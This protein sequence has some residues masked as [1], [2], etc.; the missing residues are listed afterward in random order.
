MLRS[1]LPPPSDLGLRWCL[2]FT[3]S[4][5]VDCAT[6]CRQ[7]VKLVDFDGL[8][9]HSHHLIKRGELHLFLCADAQEVALAQVHERL[10]LAHKDFHGS[11]SLREIPRH[12]KRMGTNHHRWDSNT[13]LLVRDVDNESVESEMFGVGRLTSATDK[14]LL[15]G[16]AFPAAVSYHA[17][18]GFNISDVCQDHRR[19]YHLLGLCHLRLDGRCDE[20]EDES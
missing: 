15:R 1:S 6:V 16:V 14:P 8:P 10:F 13:V 11:P 12:R 20:N 9:Q 17:E 18:C 5:L 3:H 2:S 4:P 19:V 7:V